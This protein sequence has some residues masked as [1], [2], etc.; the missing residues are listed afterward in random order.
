MHIE[1]IV[2]SQTPITRRGLT[3][4]TFARYCVPWLSQY[5]GKAI[6]MDADIVVRGDIHELAEAADPIAA[7]SVVKGQLRFE[8]P[9]V[10]VFQNALCRGLTPTYINDPATAPQK[11]DW[12][13]PIGSLPPEWNFCVGYDAPT[14]AEPKLIHYTQGIPCFPETKDC[15]YAMTW[16]EEMKHAIATVPWAGLMA[17]SVHAEHVYK[18][19]NANRA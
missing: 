7:V 9:S 6:F 16:Q 17:G 18:R 8:W 11:L 3:D 1:P 12:S 10:M 14:K 5:H 13:V 2:L 4:F 19:L 15:D